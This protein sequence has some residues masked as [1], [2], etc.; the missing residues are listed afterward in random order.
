M[1]RGRLGDKIPYEQ[2]EELSC[3]AGRIAIFLSE[4]D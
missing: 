1:A 2:V 3:A 4:T